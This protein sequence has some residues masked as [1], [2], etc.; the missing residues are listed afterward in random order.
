MIERELTPRDI[1]AVLAMQSAVHKRMARQDWLV[2]TSREQ[3]AYIFGGG[4]YGVGLFEGEA[5]LGAWVL[6]YPFEREDAL[7]R[8]MGL[9]EGKTAHYE[10]AML[11]PSLRGQGLH[12]KMVKKLTE[13][14]AKDGRFAYIAA[15]AHPDNQASVRGFTGSG[16]KVYDTREMYG[17]VMRCILYKKL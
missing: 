7:S 15:T 11:D 12:G 5:L 10:L 2:E 8:V 16:Y 6:Y 4:G 3:F 13:H 14:A 17:G 9:E 1:D